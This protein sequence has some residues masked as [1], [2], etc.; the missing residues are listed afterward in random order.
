MVREIAALHKVPPGEV[1][2]DERVL[3][4]A[5]FGATPPLFE[6]FVAEPPPGEATSDG[7]ALLGYVLSVDTFSARTG[8][9]LY[10]DNLYVRPPWRGLKLGRRLVEAAAQAAWARGGRAA[11]A[12]SIVAMSYRVCAWG[13]R[14]VGDVMR[15]ITEAA[16]SLGEQAS[17]T[18]TAQ[19]LLVE[20]FGPRPKFGCLVAE[21]AG[22]KGRAVGLLLHHVSF[23]TWTGRVLCGEGL[24][25]AP[26]HRGRGVGRALVQNA[27]KVALAQGCSQ[28]RVLVPGGPGGPWGLLTYLGG[29]D[30]TA[31]D[32]WS[33]WHVPTPA[34]AALA[35]AD[36]QR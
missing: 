24:Y 8:P 17:V 16:T 27:A 2:T 34:M 4:E 22:Q 29:T 30:V 13:R 7:R 21:A 19:G 32:G 26:P 33:V 10:L 5:G 14:H 28:L 18:I 25:V 1:T 11:A 20:G 31:R 23:C 3:L 12:A 15:L 6:C 35:A 36:P 9:G